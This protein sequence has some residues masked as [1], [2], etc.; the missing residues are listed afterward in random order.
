MIMNESP[1]P[2]IWVGVDVSKKKFDLYFE[3][4]DGRSRRKAFP[5]HAEGFAALLAWGKAQGLDWTQTG[6][7]LEATGNYS[8]PLSAALHEAGAYVAIENP[9]RIQAF[10][11]TLGVRVKTDRVDAE[12]IARYATQHTPRRWLPPSPQEVRL[13]ELVGRLDDLIVMRTME[14][15][16][17]QQL[18]GEALA[19]VTNVLKTLD[20]EIARLRAAIG[21]HID[22]DPDQRQQAELLGSIPGIGQET[23]SRVLAYLGTLSRFENVRQV[24]AFVGLNPRVRQSGQWTGASPISKQGSSVLRKALYMPALVAKRHNPV[25]RA[26]CERLTSHGKRPKQVVVAAMRKLLHLIWGVLKSKRPFDP[27]MGLP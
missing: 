20:D 10:A 26:F 15:A 9:A 21:D 7:C 3:R 24:V 17:A 18:Q 6:V 14:L 25:L 2:F 11:R 19:S 13:L 1:A 8:K 23:I 27:A 22:N 16:R 12:L 4:A 5:N